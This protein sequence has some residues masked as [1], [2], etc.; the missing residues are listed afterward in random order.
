MSKP[1]LACLSPALA[2]INAALEAGTS[3]RSIASAHGL[4]RG[5]VVRHAAHRICRSPTAATTDPARPAAPTTAG[6]PTVAPVGPASPPATAD[7]ERR[8]TQSKLRDALDRV[9]ELVKLGRMSKAE[10]AEKTK[11][12]RVAL[13]RLSPK[14]TRAQVAGLLAEGAPRADGAP[15][16]VPPTADRAELLAHLWTL[17]RFGK[18]EGAR[19]AALARLDDCLPVDAPLDDHEP[20]PA[21]ARRE[22]ARLFGDSV[23]APEA[24]P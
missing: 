14:P 9:A 8:A 11:A 2:A 15:D 23:V 13:D 20:T 16:A 17:A 24:S 5:S 22:I 21:D 6:E 7:D 19:V 1:C 3:T 18:T 12:L 10:G 4:S